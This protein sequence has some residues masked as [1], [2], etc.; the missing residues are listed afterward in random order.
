M[1]DATHIAFIIVVIPGLT[2]SPTPGVP[3]P[4]SRSPTG[5]PTIAPTHLTPTPTQGLGGS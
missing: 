2:G 1:P 3:T 5:S 4:T